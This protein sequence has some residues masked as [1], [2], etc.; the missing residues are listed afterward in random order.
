MTSN[1]RKA[2]KIIWLLLLIT[3]PVTLVFSVIG[4][5]GSPL[6]DA[7]FSGQIT[8]EQ[9]AILDN[10]QFFIGLNEKEHSNN[11]RIILKKSLSS[12]TP[13]VYGISATSNEAS[14]LGALGEKGVYAFSVDHAV[15]RIRIYDDLKKVELLSVDLPWD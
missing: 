3:V 5:S 7:D 9:E 4:I 12:P 15:K 14:S 6:T 8:E 10:D 11:L 1:L 13:I 2:H